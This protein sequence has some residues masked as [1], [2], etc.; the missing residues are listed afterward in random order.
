MLGFNISLGDTI[1][2]RTDTLKE[3]WG[4]VEMDVLGR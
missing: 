4:T 3:E 1:Q 2:P